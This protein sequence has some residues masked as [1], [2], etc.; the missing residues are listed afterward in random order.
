MRLAMV[1]SKIASLNPLLSLNMGHTP[2]PTSSFG[3]YDDHEI[4]HNEKSSVPAIVA[5]EAEALKIAREQRWQADQF[6]EKMEQELEHAGQSKRFAVI[7]FKN[8]K[9]FTWV[10]VIFA[11]M[12]GMLFGLDHS[13]IS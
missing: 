7:K 9:H 11:S 1:T 12:G 5:N 4:L 10:I 8:P 6:I 3:K 2:S 13:L